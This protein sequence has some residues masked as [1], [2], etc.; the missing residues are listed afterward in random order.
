MPTLFP[1]LLAD[2]GAE[3]IRLGRFKEAMELFK[4]LIRQDPQ[5]EWRQY[6]ADA[7]AG[8]ACAL[9][10][11]G[12][13]KEAAIV[14]ENTLTPDG[15][16]REP[17][18]YLSC[19]IRQ[20]Q[21]QKAA[22]IAIKYL[23]AN[24]G[25]TEAG[26]VAEIAAALLLAAPVPTEAGSPADAGW[27]EL[28]RAAHGALDAWVQGKRPEDVEALLARI[29]LRSPFAPLRVLLKSLISPHHTSGNALRLLRMIPADSVFAGVRT[30]AEAALAED[31]AA[32]LGRWTSLSP[33]QQTF[34]A[35]TRGLPRAGTELLGKILDAERRGPAALFDLLIRPG[36]ALPANALRAASLDLLPLIPGSIQ[37]FER[38]FGALSML[39]RNRVLALAAET[40]GRWRQAQQ[41]WDSVVASLGGDAGSDARLAQAVVLRHLAD[42]AQC[43]PEVEAGPG[44]DA[45]VH[46]L[47][48]S[49]EADPDHLP[50]TLSL[51]EQYRRADDPKAW[52]R[53]TERAVERTAPYCCTRWMRRWHAMP[54]RRRPAS[55][56][57]C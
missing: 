48:R 35:E 33:A 52:F 36:L 53:M 50:A 49:L 28:I 30:A 23:S 39:E 26:R 14:L 47:A 12:M 46:Y 37:P 13:F 6:L 20:S 15:T 1:A 25:T 31:A 24:R 38:R 43:H 27:S 4:Q 51:I 2:R 34:V 56:G 40:Q 22:R 10:D 3:A 5:P 42:L 16:V 11:K 45:V 29:P 21:H 32:L 57:A 7:Y 17:A 55:R 44:T 9:A 18:L 54:T 8:R 41:H 19:L